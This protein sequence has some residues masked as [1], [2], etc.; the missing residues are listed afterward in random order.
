MHRARVVINYIRRP[1]CDIPAAHGN[2]QCNR[3]FVRMNPSLLAK[4]KEVVSAAGGRAGP[5]KLY[6]EAVITADTDQRTCP[7]DMKQ[8]C[9]TILKLLFNLWFGNK[10]INIHV[11]QLTQC[12][13]CVVAGLPQMIADFQEIN[14]GVHDIMTQLSQWEISMYQH[15]YII[16]RCLLIA[17]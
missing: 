16:T 10:S 1:E 5:A 3:P 9:I 12:N 14:S 8:V 13:L 6:K 7:R 4:I 17:L 15:Y 2:S 11:L